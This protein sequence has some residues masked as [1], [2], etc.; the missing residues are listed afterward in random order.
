MI[1]LK[2]TIKNTILFI[3][4][5]NNNLPS[6]IFP[7]SNHNSIKKLISKK[8]NYHLNKNKTLYSFFSIN[9]HQTYFKNNT[10]KN[11]YK[12]LTLFINYT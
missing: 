7:K 1:N 4:F 2:H 5:I 8:K 6:K 11:H 12:H 3:Q 9:I 10:K